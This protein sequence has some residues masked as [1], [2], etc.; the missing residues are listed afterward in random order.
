MKT[1]REEKRELLK[2]LREDL[3]GKKIIACVCYV[4]SSGMS[5]HIKFCYVGNNG[6]LYNISYKVSKILGY[7]YNNNDNSVIVGGC[8]MDLIFHCLYNLNSWALELGVIKPSKKKDR[9]TLQYNG[10][11]NTNYNYI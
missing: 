1:T 6:Y 5:R 4:S 11:V 3:K 8:G 7:R 9:H 2:E 10:V